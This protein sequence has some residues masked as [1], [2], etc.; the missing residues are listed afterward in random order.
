MK[1]LCLHLLSFT[2]NHFK[3]W[4]FVSLYLVSVSIVKHHR[5][6]FQHSVIIWHQLWGCAISHA[7]VPRSQIQFSVRCINSHLVQTNLSF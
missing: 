3:G 5:H 1:N 6:V 2:L 7:K 4:E